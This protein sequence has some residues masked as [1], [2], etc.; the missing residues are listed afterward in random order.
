MEPRGPGAL[1]MGG[2]GHDS[3]STWPSF[4][5]TKLV[6]GQRGLEPRLIANRY[7]LGPLIGTG[8]TAQVFQARDR[9]ENREVAVKLFLPGTATRQIREAA[10][11][12]GLDHPGLITLSGFGTHDGR[13][14]LVM[15]LVD[16]PTLG[17]RLRARTLTPDEVTTLAVRLAD[18]LAY[19]HRHGVTHRDLKPGNI[20]LAGDEP[21]LG[22]FG[23]AHLVDATAITQTG[24]VVGT[25]A[26]MAPEQVLSQEVG[27]AADIYALGLVLLEC[28][29]GHR[30]YP[31][32]AVESAVARVHRQPVIPPDLPGELSPLLR[33]MTARKPEKRPTAAQVAAMLTRP[34]GIPEQRGVRRGRVAAALGLLTA[35]SLTFAVGKSP[36]S[37]PRPVTPPQ[38]IA[39]PGTTTTPPD[40]P[41]PLPAVATAELP[42]IQQQQQQKDQAAPV[43]TDEGKTPKKGKPEKGK[44]PKE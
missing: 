31:G 42:A 11:L 29:T 10:I 4:E 39:D 5:L 16:G 35:V 15:R 27:P 37:A 34:V 19:I 26:Y 24:E 2:K 28:L 44:G 36:D 22:D 30:E 33:R 21:L 1:A 14:Y 7:E 12:R 20:L 8:A 18:A 9:L 17:A 38:Q 40:V 43:R 13:P 23:I 25:A 3:T 32:T 6:P 41:I